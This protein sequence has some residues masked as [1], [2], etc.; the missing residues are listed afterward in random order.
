MSRIPRFLKSDTSTIYHIMS[1]TALDGYPLSDVGKEVL[2]ELIRKFSSFYVVDVL[3]FALMGNHFHLAVRMHSTNEISDDA[4]RKRMETWYADG[5]FITP[6]AISRH[7][8]M[9]TSLS[10]YMK[11]IKQ[12]FTRYYNKTHN[13]RG[14]FW[15]DRFKSVIVEDG[16]TLINLLAYIDLNPVRAGL[17]QKPEDYRWNTLGYHTG[18]GN[19]DEFLNTDFGMKEWNEYDPA[20]ILSKYREF[21]YETGALDTG[22]GKA[23]DSAL[24]QAERIKKYLLTRAER[25]KYRTRYFTDS[26]IIGSKAFVQEAFDGIKH[27]LGSKDERRFTPVAGVKGMYSMKKLQG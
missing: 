10:H 13:R 5:R 18:N 2:L 6:A 3:G 22:K 21:V 16:P 15:G 7:K 12:A 23:M 27:L 26:G 20:E 17:V 24:V 19:I 9:L 1:R 8:K 14:F 25:F 4:I 11:S